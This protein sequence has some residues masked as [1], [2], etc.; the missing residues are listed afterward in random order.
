MLRLVH[1]NPLRQYELPA[2]NKTEND[3][4]RGEYEEL[5]SDVLN[6]V[7]F[8]RIA[9]QRSPEAINFWLGRCI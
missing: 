2:N 4:L 1:S 8:A 5:F 3:N 9:L 6:S 7:P